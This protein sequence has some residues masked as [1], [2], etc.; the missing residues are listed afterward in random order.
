[1]L[2]DLM[3]AKTTA[4]ITMTIQQ[5]FGDKL[6]WHSTITM[7]VSTARQCAQFV[8]DYQYHASHVEEWTV[9]LTHTLTTEE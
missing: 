7:D 6:V 2:S 8:H 9:T 4:T 1:M 3:L 5:T